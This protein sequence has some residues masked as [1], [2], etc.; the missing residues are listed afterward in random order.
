MINATSAREIARGEG[1][2]VG[3]LD[4]GI[5]KNHPDLQANIIGGLNLVKKAGNSSKWD[6]DNGHGTHI[7]GVIAA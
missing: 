7:A 4:T 1:V 6:D 5:Q 2:K 3:I